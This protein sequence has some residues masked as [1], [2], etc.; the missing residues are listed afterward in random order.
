MFR[1]AEKYQVD[2]GDENGVYLPIHYKYL[3]SIYHVSLRY[4]LPGLDFQADQ[5]HALK[6]FI[7]SKDNKPKK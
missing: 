6:E 5:I 1:Y 3:S 4:W 7:F 2:K